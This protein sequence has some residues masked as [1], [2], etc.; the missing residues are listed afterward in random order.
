M[1]LNKYIFDDD[2]QSVVNHVLHIDFDKYPSCKSDLGDRDMPGGCSKI[3]QILSQ[4]CTS[5]S[6]FGDQPKNPT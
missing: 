1:D 3:P 6:G 5:A 4:K 2:I